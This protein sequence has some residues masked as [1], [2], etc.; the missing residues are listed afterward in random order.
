MA[1]KY[2]RML[3]PQAIA[4]QQ[5]VGDERHTVESVNYIK[6]ELTCSC[7]EWSGPAL[8]LAPFRAHRRRFFRAR[9]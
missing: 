7:G 5:R 2:D 3:S 8:D 4:K 6:D 9:K 1:T